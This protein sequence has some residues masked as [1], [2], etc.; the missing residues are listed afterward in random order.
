MESR[1]DTLAVV[2][3]AGGGWV[4]CLQVFSI[5]HRSTAP[6]RFPEGRCITLSVSTFMLLQRAADGPTE[7]WC[8]SW[9]FQTLLLPV[10]AKATANAQISE[11]II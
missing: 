9:C 1:D 10:L 5:E 11:V 2:I 7:H 4:R 3:A 8:L 6:I